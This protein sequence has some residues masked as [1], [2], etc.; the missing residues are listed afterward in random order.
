M[1]VEANGSIPLKI[2]ATGL[3]EGALKQA[4]NLVELPFAFKHVAIMPDGHQG[5]GMPIGGV[6]A[7]SGVIVPNAVGKDIGCGVCSWNTG[8]SVDE[9]MRNRDAIMQDVRRS[10]PVG[11]NWHDKPQ[12]HK[13]VLDAA[14]DGSLPVIMEQFQRATHQIGTLGGGNHFVEIQKDEEDAVLVMIHSGSRNLGSKVA[15]YY[16]AVARKLNERWHSEVPKEWELA[17]LPLDTDEG[18]MYLAE[19]GV[20]LEFARL[21]RAHMMEAV[22]AVFERHLGSTRYDAID[23]HHNYAVQEH[24]FGRNVW[25]HRKGAVKAVGDVLIPGSMGSHSYIGRGLENYDSFKSCS[26]GAGRAMGRKAADRTIPV[27]D[28]IDEMAK[29]DVMYASLDTSSIV[30]ESR[31]AYKDIDVVM[32]NQADLVEVTS[33]LTPMAVLK[34]AKKTHKKA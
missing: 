24:H 22:N 15:D 23:I 13:G 28:V 27:K 10:I 14:L 11:F 30:E 8:A 20:C 21:N 17:F 32:A 26:H 29:L 6:L 34:A 3:E 5:Y 4:R 1:L 9:F 33:K 7:T 19:M 2:W 16:D 12:D 18:Q 25:V 31:Q